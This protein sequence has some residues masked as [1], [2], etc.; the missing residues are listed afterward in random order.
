MRFGLVLNGVFWGVFLIFL[1]LCA[2]FKTVFHINISVFRIG[3][4]L[5]I[6]YIGLSMLFNGPHFRVEKNTV[7]F[8][9]REIAVDEQD[10]YNV[11]FGRGIIDLTTLPAERRTRRTE[12]NVVFGEGIIEINPEVPMK[13]KVNSAFSGTKLPDG[14]RISMGEYIYRTEN[15]TENNEGIQVNANVVFG[16]LVFVEK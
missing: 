8:D 2:I 7:L 13:I 4:A 12:I 1:G 9:N 5:L 10:E 14:N 6:I 3:L 16:S 11:V 15:Y